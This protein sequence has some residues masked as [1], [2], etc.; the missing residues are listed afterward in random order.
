MSDR[1]QSKSKTPIRN[2]EGNIIHND[3]DGGDIWWIHFVGRSEEK[4]CMMVNNISVHTHGSQ[5]RRR[6]RLSIRK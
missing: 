1:R 3:G 6:D 2:R 5:S 4:G